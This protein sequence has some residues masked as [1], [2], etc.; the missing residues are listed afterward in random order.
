MSR[1]LTLT[2][3]LLL[4]SSGI[5]GA[6]ECP[7]TNLIEDP[8]PFQWTYQGSYWTGTLEIGPADFEIGTDSLRTRAYRLPGG[9]FTIPGPTIS[10][11]PGE[12]Y[13]LTFRN[14]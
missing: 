7:D 1:S 12:S 5:A 3:I 2:F 9:V 14:V 11:T 10:M 8:P 13:V 4:I 6:G